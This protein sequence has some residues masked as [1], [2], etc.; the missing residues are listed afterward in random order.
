MST[1]DGSDLGRHIVQMYTVNMHFGTL[2]GK[3]Y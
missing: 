3:Y 1:T 2:H